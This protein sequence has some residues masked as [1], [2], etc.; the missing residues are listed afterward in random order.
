MTENAQ[1]VKEKYKNFNQTPLNE[2]YAIHHPVA[3]Y[4]QPVMRYASGNFA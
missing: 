1:N 4:I 2:G 3:H